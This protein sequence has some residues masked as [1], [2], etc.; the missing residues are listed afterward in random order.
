MPDIKVTLEPRLV[1]A[2]AEILQQ[3]Q[4]LEQLQVVQATA[5]QTRMRELNLRESNYGIDDIACLGLSYRKV[6]IILG[7]L[8]VLCIAYLTIWF[9]RLSEKVSPNTGL[10]QRNISHIP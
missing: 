9:I 3:Q 5:T 6:F 7:V 4:E 1:I 8:L 2:R 10:N